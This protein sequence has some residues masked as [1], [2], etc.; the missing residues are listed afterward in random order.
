VTS[1]QE[2][3]YY[4][5]QDKKIKMLP[6]CASCVNAISFYT[7]T[8]SYIKKSINIIFLMLFVSA[9]F[10]AG[11]GKSSFVM[12]DKDKHYKETLEFT[13]KK[14]LKN[15]LQTVA[16]FRATYLNKVYPQ[17]YKDNEYFFI[18]VYIPDDIKKK[19]GLLNPLFELLLN[20]K[21]PLKITELKHNSSSLIKKM[22]LTNRWT[23]YYIVEFEK[24][25][26]YN[27]LLTYTHLPSA[28][29]VEFLFSH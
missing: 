18:G 3:I 8:T 13:Q 14:Q 11:C 4:V 2:N 25:D 22:P 24:I 9:V 28:K 12:L 1:F 29:G 15:Y 23:K 10:F 19:K 26:E 16:V 21:E 7:N 17:D 27:L 5:N 20:G 6:K